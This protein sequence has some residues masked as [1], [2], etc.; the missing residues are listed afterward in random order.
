MD[1][2]KNKCGALRLSSL[3]RRQKFQ[4]TNV[5]WQ[6]S[7]RERAERRSECGGERAGDSRPEGDQKGAG[8]RATAGQVLAQEAAVV[9]GPSRSRKTCA[10]TCSRAQ[11]KK[12]RTP[13]II[14]IIS[15]QLFAL[16]PTAQRFSL[17]G[18]GWR[19]LARPPDGTIFSEWARDASRRRYERGMLSARSHPPSRPL[20]FPEPAPNS[21]AGN[22]VSVCKADSRCAG[23]DCVMSSLGLGNSFLK[24]RTDGRA[25][26]YARLV[27]HPLWIYAPNT[28]YRWRA[29]LTN[30]VIPGWRISQAHLV[31]LWCFLFLFL[32][33]NATCWTACQ[34]GTVWTRLKYSAL[35]GCFEQITNLI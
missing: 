22:R 1:W 18:W 23:F 11:P 21:S 16:G 12:Q 34:V 17:D 4:S 13:S 3:G 31:D 8:A 32:L 25:R 20:P 9:G 2:I 6:P 35:R 27:N 28:H 14:F 19:P 26:H 10:F 5:H 29:A 24:R 7:E 33:I 30:M 15:L